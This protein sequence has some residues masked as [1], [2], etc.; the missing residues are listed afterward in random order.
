[1]PDIVLRV[2]LVAAVVAVTIAA[3]WWWERRDGRVRGGTGGFTRAQLAAVGLAP[4]RRDPVALLL[5]SPTCAPCVTVKH[6]L[7][8]VEQVRPGF[9]WVDVDAADH[10]DLADAHHVMRV[11]TLFVIDPDGRILAR[12]SGVPAVQDLVAVID[13]EADLT[14]A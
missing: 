11:P 3:G 2:L 12:T 10:L 5:G 9:R 7:A 13:R 4:A 14:A 1:M 6:V 8:Q